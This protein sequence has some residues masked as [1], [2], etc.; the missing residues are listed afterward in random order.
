MRIVRIVVRVSGAAMAERD[1]MTVRE[2]GVLILNGFGHQTIVQNDK[3]VVV[4][5]G[6]GQ[7]GLIFTDP[8]VVDVE[9]RV[10]IR[11]QVY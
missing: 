2:V 9:H 7:G 11:F 3:V 8:L 5:I 4:L 1:V 10:Q 6:R